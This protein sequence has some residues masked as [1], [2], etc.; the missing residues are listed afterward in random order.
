MAD[1][2]EKEVDRNRD[3]RNRAEDHNASA[4]QRKQDRVSA[5]WN[6]LG[7]RLTTITGTTL[8][9]S[10]LILAPG[11][12]LAHVWLLKFTWP[13]LLGSLIFGLYRYYYDW[14]SARAEENEKILHG[15]W[16]KLSKLMMFLAAAFLL[17]GLA[18]FVGF[19]LINVG[20]LSASTD[21]ASTEP[22]S[23]G[24]LPP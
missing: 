23:N 5:A 22:V 2:F 11:V 3:A 9:L 24:T 18:T 6:A 21:N 1:Q 10:I 17:I 13:V 4:E 19:L 15:G 8:G 7:D 14:Q 20:T 16:G 12:S